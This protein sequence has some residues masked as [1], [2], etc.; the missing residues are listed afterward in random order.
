MVEDVLMMAVD[1]DIGRFDL[2]PYDSKLVSLFGVQI[3][4]NRVI[5]L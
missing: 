3:L 1:Y 5:G 4:C 2:A